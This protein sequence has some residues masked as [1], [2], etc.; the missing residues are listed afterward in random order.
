[1]HDI[2]HSAAT[3]V[4]RWRGAAESGDVDAAV[5]CLSPDIVLSSPLTE[6]FR[7]EGSD[8]LRDFLASAFTA[9]ENIRFHTETG[10]GD[11]YALAYRA[12]VGNQPFEEAQLLRLDDKSHIRE[13]T[14]FGRPMPALTALMTTLGPDLARR[15]GRR[16]LATLLRASA[17]PVHA[18]VTFGD[19]TVVP[20][21]RPGAKPT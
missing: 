12:R 14:L 3:T 17:T 7:L 21:T 19:R 2:S 16:G 10:Q 11:T 20:R 8:Q 6:Q 4:A 9:I 18:M 1:M 15:Q 5:A 13:I